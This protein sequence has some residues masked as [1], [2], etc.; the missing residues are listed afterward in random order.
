MEYAKEDVVRWFCGFYEGEGWI[1]NDIG[2][3]N[4]VRAGMAQNDRTPLDIGM[5]IWGGTVRQRVRTSCVSG[6]V[7]TGH[8]WLMPHV[9]SLKFI[10]DIRPFM[11]IPQKIEQVRRVLDQFKNGEKLS[12]KCQSCEKVYA[13]PA[14]RR[15][16]FKQIHQNTDASGVITL[17]ENQTAGTS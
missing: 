11:M 8:E 7:C 5:K 9:Q 17:Q 14:A 13:N 4:R 16:H 15:R 1:S 2:N 6:K 12:Y 3:N 10:E